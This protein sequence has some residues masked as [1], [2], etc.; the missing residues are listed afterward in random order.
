MTTPTLTPVQEDVIVRLVNC[1][2]YTASVGRDLPFKCNRITARA[3]KA[4]GL[5]TIDGAIF[6]KTEPFVLTLTEVGVARAT[7]L[8]KGSR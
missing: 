7:A 3:L 2:H 6:R 1:P 8:T 4:L 5:V